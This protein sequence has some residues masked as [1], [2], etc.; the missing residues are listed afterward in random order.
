MSEET[1][2]S[3]HK[4]LEA[5]EKQPKTIQLDPDGCGAIID[6]D[7]YQRICF[8]FDADVCLAIPEECIREVYRQVPPDNFWDTYPKKS[9]ED[10]AAYVRANFAAALRP[11]GKAHVEPAPAAPVAT[12][13]EPAKAKTTSS[14]TRGKGNS[15]A[16]PF[17]VDE[18]VAKIKA[19]KRPRL[20]QRLSGEYQIQF[21][22]RPIE[23]LPSFCMV[24]HYRTCVYPGKYGLGKVV[25]SYDL[26][27]G[28]KREISFQTYEHREETKTASQSVF[29]SFSA[30]SA[31]SFENTLNNTISAT[32]DTTTDNKTNWNASTAINLSLSIPQ[33]SLAINL[34]AGTGGSTSTSA[35]TQNHSETISTAISK[36]SSEANRLREISTGSETS[37]TMSSGTDSSI[38]RELTNP[39]WSRT[40]NF[41]FRQL[42]QQYTA[43][44]YLDNVSFRFSNGFVTKCANLSNLESMLEE[45][46]AN[47]ECIANILAG[48]R[49]ELCNILGYDG[50]YHSLIECCPYEPTDCCDPRNIRP[51]TIVIQKKRGLEMCYDKYCVPG[52]ITCV[53][54]FVMRT[55][56]V[57]VDTVM[58]QNDSLDCYHSRLENAEAESKELDNEVR[59][60]RER[61]IAS[62]CYPESQ[63]RAAIEFKRAECCPEVLCEC[64]KTEGRLPNREHSE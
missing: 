57:F 24:L 34:T 4:I 55:P 27:P 49:M 7:L 8:S 46:G 64:R 45:I 44:T 41:F 62:Q 14:S 3:K 1:C 52:I 19:G 48:I 60:N 20:I 11:G 59:R 42:N 13:A 17:D 15:G 28:E 47:E 39:N 43:V 37:S 58:G 22:D 33:G 61:I 5:C 38:T 26:L 9:D 36:H 29:D 31:D 50:N 51:K 10:L 56:A 16:G 12:P 54:H 30:S 23:V 2:C 21:Q 32:S 6:Y 18:I 35:H 63:V 53:Q 40:L 25:G